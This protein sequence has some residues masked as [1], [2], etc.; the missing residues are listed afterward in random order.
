V[1]LLQRF[2][3]REG[4]IQGDLSHAPLSPRRRCDG[5]SDDDDAIVAG[6]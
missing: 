3:P 5:A 2:E 6:R 4:F 1:S